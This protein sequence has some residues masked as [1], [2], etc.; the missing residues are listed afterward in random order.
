MPQKKQKPTPTVAWCRARCQK[1]LSSPYIIIVCIARHLYLCC[2]AT[3]RYCRS[4]TTARVA[5]ADDSVSESNRPN[6][7]DEGCEFFAYYNSMKI[8]EHQQL[9]KR[10]C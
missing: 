6:P 7:H 3:N 8:G 4:A 5:A 2:K 1:G 10:E 9:T